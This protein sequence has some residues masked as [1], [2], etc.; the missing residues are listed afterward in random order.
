MRAMDFPHHKPSDPWL[1]RWAPLVLVAVALLVLLPGTDLAPLIDRDE[2]RFAQATREMIQRGEW[3]VPYFNEAYR[4]DKPILI[5]WMMRLS[6]AALGVNELSARLPSVL[7][8]IGMAW[9]IYFLGRRWFSWRAGFF[10]AFGMLTCVQ[11]LMHGRSAV[12]DMPMIAMVVLAQWAAY[13]LIH[14]EGPDYPWRWFWAFYLAQGIGFLA[15]GPVVMVVALLTF[16]A[17]RFLFWRKPLAWRRLKLGLGIPIVLAIMGAWGIPALVKTHGEFWTVGMY[18]HV[19]ERG[20]DTFDGHAAFFAYYIVIALISLFPWIAYLGDGVTIL[21][22]QWNERNAYL[23]SWVLTTYVLFSFYMT[24]LPHYVMPA[25][26]A[27]FLILGQAWEPRFVAP[28]AARVWFWL[29]ISLI[30]GLSLIGLVAA[31]SIPFSPPFAHMRDVIA[32]AGGAAVALAALAILW[33]LRLAGYS[34]IPLTGIAIS[35]FLLGS[36]LRQMT[37]AI[38]LQEHFDRLPPNVQYGFY[39]YKEPSLVFYTNHKWEILDSMDEVNRFL[40]APGPR[41]VVIS[42]QETRLEDYIAWLRARAAGRPEPLVVRDYAE[43]VAA[44]DTNGCTVVSLDGINIART[45][46]ARVRAA[47]RN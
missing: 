34:A 3:V 24:K 31:R 15:K 33:R 35:M 37:P 42:E 9:L 47:Y 45:C 41:F 23:V 21:R 38:L 6:Y 17:Q 7:S 11:L 16:L 20:W 14:D 19:F 13:E 18:S 32:G 43:D 40:H 36:G 39:R 1:S 46:S 26:P 29:V 2:P 22:R 4:F 44:L 25:F 10:A 27:I 30:G 28:R 12:A 8:A 5:Y